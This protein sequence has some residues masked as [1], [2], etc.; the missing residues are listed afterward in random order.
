MQRAPVHRVVY[1]VRVSVSV[2]VRVSV[3]VVHST[4]HGR[5]SITR[6]SWILEDNVHNLLVVKHV[7]NSIAGQHYKLIP[8]QDVPYFNIRGGN[9]ALVGFFEP[10][11]SKRLQCSDAI[12]SVNWLEKWTPERKSLQANMRRI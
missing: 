2:S 6:C 3:S 8:R 1:R 4:H 5:C 9:D 10:N 7:K 11:V 12:S